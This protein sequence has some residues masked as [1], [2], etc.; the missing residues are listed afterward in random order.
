MAT[1]KGPTGLRKFRAP[2]D[3]WK[4]FG[5]GVEASPDPEADMSKVLR[6]FLRWYVHETGARLPDRPPAGPWSTPDSEDPS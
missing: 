5:D 1:A 3:L 4:R 6:Q 2:T